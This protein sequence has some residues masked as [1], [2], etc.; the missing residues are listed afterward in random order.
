MTCHQ[1]LNSLYL[2]HH[3][4]NSWCWFCFFEFRETIFNQSA[5]VF[6]LSNFLNDYSYSFGFILQISRVTMRYSCIHTEPSPPGNANTFYG[7]GGE[8]GLLFTKTAH[9][10]TRKMYQNK[11]GNESLN[12]PL[13]KQNKPAILL[14]F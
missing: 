8:Y 4:V 13:L 6:S 14:F 2:Y 1:H 11:D 3:Y 7:G 10:N 9:C 12:N 5:C